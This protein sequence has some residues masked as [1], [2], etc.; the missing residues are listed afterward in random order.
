MPRSTVLTSPAYFVCLRD[1]DLTMRSRNYA[2]LEHKFVGWIITDEIRILRCERKNV[3]LAYLGSLIHTV[4]FSPRVIL[5]RMRAPV[6][7]AETDRKKPIS[8]AG[9]VNFFWLWK[10][11]DRCSKTF[12]TW[13]HS[14]T[15][16]DCNDMEFYSTAA[17]FHSHNRIKI[18]YSLVC[19]LFFSL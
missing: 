2:S 12:A 14:V 19:C 1:F 5:T 17:P 16:P 8:F 4:V 10:W 6:C 7:G 9:A 11:K 15:H 13:K 18:F 3:H